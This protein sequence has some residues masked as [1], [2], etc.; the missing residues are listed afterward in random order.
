MSK[1]YKMFETIH[2]FHSHY[3]VDVFGLVRA[4]GIDLV[5]KPLSASEAGSIEPIAHDRYRFVINADHPSTRRR[6]TAAH[7]LGHYVFHRDRIGA[8]V[9]DDLAYRNA[10]DGPHFNT[11]IGMRQETEANRFATTLLMPSMLLD[12]RQAELTDKN[13]HLAMSEI[14]ERMACDFQ[15]TA[16]AMRIR[17][18]LPAV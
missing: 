14:A 5:E 2:A 9:C 1:L 15:V 10:P 8:G 3:P 4:L 17:L 11:A 13:P 7:Q 18:G 6:F 16:N 12:A